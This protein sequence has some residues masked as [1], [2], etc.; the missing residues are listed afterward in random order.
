[1]VV[2]AEISP[3]NLLKIN[4]FKLYVPACVLTQ[5][6]SFTFTLLSLY[7][8]CMLRV[9][10]SLYQGVKHKLLSWDKTIIASL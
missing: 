5:L 9:T 2:G 10:F 8:Y 3:F 1:M 4:I 6:F 7:Y